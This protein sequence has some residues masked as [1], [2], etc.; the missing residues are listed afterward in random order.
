M[1]SEQICVVRPGW[2]ARSLMLSLLSCDL[3]PPQ[4]ARTESLGKEPEGVE[5]EMMTASMETTFSENSSL[6]NTSS[7]SADQPVY[8]R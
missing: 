3:P 8:F 2:K 4:I 5:A 6:S 1:D 7:S